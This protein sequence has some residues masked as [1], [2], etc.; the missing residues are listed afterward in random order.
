MQAYSTRTYGG[1]VRISVEREERVVP[2]VS[3]YFPLSVTVPRASRKCI[4]VERFRPCEAA[5]SE[6]AHQRLEMGARAIAMNN[7]KVHAAPIHVQTEG[8]SAL[9]PNR[10]GGG[11]KRRGA[12]GRVRAPAAR[13]G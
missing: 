5:E 2:R 1:T 13:G 11:F 10:H 3:R 8:Q 9:E 7:G 4:N 6:D 12:R